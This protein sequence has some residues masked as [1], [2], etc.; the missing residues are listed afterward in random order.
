MMESLSLEP[1]ENDNIEEMNDLSG[2]DTSGIVVYAR[3]WTIQTIFSQIEEGNIELNP[4]FQ[5]R[6]AW[7]D[8][9]RSKLIESI[10][11]GYPIPEIVLA[12]DPVK[13]R[14]FIVIDGKQRLLSIAGFISNDKYDYW[15]KPVLQ[16]LSVCENL[17]GLT[18]SELPE[19]AK[20][21][22]DNSS[23]RC[24]VITNFRDN[25]ILYDIFYRLNSGSV[26][27]STQELR[28]ALNRG[29]FGDYLID[30]TNNICSLHNVMGL[31]NPD[32]RLRDVEILLRI[33]SFYLYARDYKGN[34]RFF[35]DDKMRYIN[36]NWNSMKNEVE[37]IYSMINESI[38]LLCQVFED[39]KNIGRKYKNGQFEKR[40]NKVLFEV[41]V[42]YFMHLLEHKELVREKKVNLLQSFKSLCEED[43]LFMSSLESSTKNI[44]NYKIRYSKIENLVNDTL[45][46][47]LQINPFR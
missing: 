10:I 19:T 36:E 32:T 21:E 29:A 23:L 17:N 6:N 25:Q 31:D 35:L 5:R 24:T 28:Q 16:K 8:D 45:D 30:V 26:A 27:L 37:Q 22:F 3:D 13:K 40:F 11:M 9:R 42:F 1:V 39:N 2:L 47:R 20:R 43:T 44:D 7:Q 14:S 34:L 4:K 38:A 33:I 18:Y 46:I 41:E 15:K 12:E